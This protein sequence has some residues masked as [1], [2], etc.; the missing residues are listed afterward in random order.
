MPTIYQRARG[1]M[2]GTLSLCP[3]YGTCE[4]HTVY[5]HADYNFAR[6]ASQIPIIRIRVKPIISENQK[7][8]AS[9]FAQIKG[10]TASVIT[11]R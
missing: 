7:Y 6:R 2:V 4:G 1:E 5:A 8:P 11:A 3:P 9:L 10:I